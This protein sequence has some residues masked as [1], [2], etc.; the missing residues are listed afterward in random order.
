MPT[1]DRLSS[2]AAFSWLRGEAGRLR[3]AMMAQRLAVRMGL[4]LAPVLLLVAAAYWAA[5]TLASPGPRFLA[6][7]RALLLRRPHPGLPR[8]GRQGDLL[9]AR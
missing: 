2:T 1:N 9:S 6:Q 5:G 8:P 7:G 3:R 4:V